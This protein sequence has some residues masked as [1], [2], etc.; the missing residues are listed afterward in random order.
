MD[1]WPA[2]LGRPGIWGH[3]L[4]TF[5]L[6]RSGKLRLID[7]MS[8]SQINATVTCYEQAAVDGPAQLTDSLR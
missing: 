7:D 1:S 2:T 8:Q 4:E 6:E 5:P 3:G